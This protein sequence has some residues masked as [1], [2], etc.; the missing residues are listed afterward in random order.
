MVGLMLVFRNQTA[1]S[2]YWNGRLHLGTVTTAIRCLSRQIL[3]LSPAPSPS[4]R[5]SDPPKPSR[6]PSVFVQPPT[7]QPSSSHSAPNLDALDDSLNI[8]E[9]PSPESKVLETVNILIAMLYAVKN[10]MRADWGVA[11]S[12]GM[13]VTNDGEATIQAEYSEFLPNNLRGYEHKG[14]GLTLELSVFVE[15]FIARGV[16]Q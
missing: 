5:T 8:P 16:D 3:V 15:A 1:Y 7:L 4:R 11:L 12:P 2:R 14:L 9:E 6:E 13:H 10:H